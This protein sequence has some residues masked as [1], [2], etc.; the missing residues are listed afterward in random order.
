M[1]EIL[2]EIL[3]VQRLMGW[4]L[5]LLAF[6]DFAALVILG[7]VWY[8]TR[9]TAHAVHESAERAAQ[10]LDRISFYLFQ[11]LGPADSR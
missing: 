4:V 10:T 8:L 11:K 2:Q 5:V 7:A 9:E 6:L 1:A 3:Q